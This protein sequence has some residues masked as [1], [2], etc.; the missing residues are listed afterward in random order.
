[1]D[2]IFDSPLHHYRSLSP[3]LTAGTTSESIL[4]WT[5]PEDGLS[6]IF[7]DNPF[8]PG[9][10]GIN[11][12]TARWYLEWQ[13]EDIYGTSI[14]PQGL[15]TYPDMTPYIPA[16]SPTTEVNDEDNDQN[17]PE[18]FSAIGPT[19][20][21]RRNSR[22][23][24]SANTPYQVAS[25]ST[26]AAHSISHPKGKAN[27]SS[28][29][30]THTSKVVPSR[31]V[32]L[33]QTRPPKIPKSGKG[34]AHAH[35]PAK[36]KP[37]KKFDLDDIKLNLDTNQ[38]IEC[39]W[40]GCGDLVPINQTSLTHHIKKVK[41]HAEKVERVQCPL[42]CKDIPGNVSR[43][44]IRDHYDRVVACTIDGCDSVFK[45]D[46]NHVIR[47]LHNTARHFKLK[48][49]RDGHPLEFASFSRSKDDM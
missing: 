5:S 12:D 32:S 34:K 39:P 38:K 43:H 35:R 14:P 1:M 44:I 30:S 13:E 11:H 8:L 20:S 29:P 19:R 48:K 18:T 7:D 15:M 2:R 21:P 24:R 6:S 47:H 9:S 4:E 22:L 23:A 10:S 3:A 46:K 16:G 40:P 42:G 41:M 17:V 26:G 45:G 36:P 27:P 25:T 28:K 33:H 49:P 37:L 31:T